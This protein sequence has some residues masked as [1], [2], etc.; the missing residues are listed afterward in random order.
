MEAS[1]EFKISESVHSLERCD[2]K[3]AQISNT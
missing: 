2:N 3:D 1:V